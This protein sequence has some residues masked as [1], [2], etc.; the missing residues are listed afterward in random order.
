MP[1]LIKYYKDHSNIKNI[2]I[3]CNVIIF[4]QIASFYSH[5]SWDTKKGNENEYIGL[6]KNY[7]NLPTEIKYSVEKI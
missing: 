1:H 3:L 2:T 5:E 4:K 6:A 7:P